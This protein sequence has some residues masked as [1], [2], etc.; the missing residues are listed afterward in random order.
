VAEALTLRHVERALE[1]HVLTAA[2]LVGTY[3]R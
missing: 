2:D 1:G 3:E